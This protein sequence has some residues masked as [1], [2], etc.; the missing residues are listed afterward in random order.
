MVHCE[1]IISIRGFGKFIINEISGNT[2]NGKIIVL[3]KKFI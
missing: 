2:K 3:V 1:D